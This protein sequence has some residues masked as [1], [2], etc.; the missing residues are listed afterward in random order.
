MRRAPSVNR[1]CKICR[2]WSSP[3]HRLK[4]RQQTCGEPECQREWHRRQCEEWNRKNKEYFKGIYLKKKLSK[5][6][7]LPPDSASPKFDLKEK[8]PTITHLGSRL[9]F[10]LP[11]HDIQELINPEALVIIEY[12]AEQ[13]TQR[14]RIGIQAKLTAVSHQIQ[15]I[16]P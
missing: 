1:P 9:N 5:I 15:K 4:D 16:P 12:V 13:I 2:R 11:K 10:G 8:K 3:D 14:F 7:R 6:T